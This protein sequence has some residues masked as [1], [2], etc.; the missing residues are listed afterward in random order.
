MANG[1]VN[2]DLYS[3][4]TSKVSNVMNKLVSGEK[5]GFH[6]LSKGLIVLLCA[7]SSRPR[8]RAQRMLGV[9]SG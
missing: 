1:M 9:N 5:P 7:G 8:S 6:T 3:A 4:I 2:V